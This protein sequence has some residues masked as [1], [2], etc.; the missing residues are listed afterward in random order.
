[1][2]RAEAFFILWQQFFA[3]YCFVPFAESLDRLRSPVLS[4]CFVDLIPF[5]QDVLVSLWKQRTLEN[6]A[7]M[8]PGKIG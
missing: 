4:I 1:M 3:L 6:I 7:A 5:V 2:D 8:R